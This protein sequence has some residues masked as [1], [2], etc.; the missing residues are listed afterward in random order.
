VPLR[1]LCLFSAFGLGGCLSNDPFETA[2]PA[3]TAEKQL[4]IAT[5]RNELYD[6][7]SIRGAELSEVIT[8]EDGNT[9]RRIV[10]ARYDSKAKNGEWT[11]RE[12]HLVAIS[13]ASTVM[14]S[15]RVPDTEMPCDRL[16]YA[17]FPEAEGLRRR[18]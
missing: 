9:R 11:G 1:F 13:G 8:L 2:R 15:L 4:V 18:G 12:T 17:P 6:P 10:C 7:F 3:T 5:A 16:K 14:S